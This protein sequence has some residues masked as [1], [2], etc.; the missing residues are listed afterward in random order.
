ME[1]DYNLRH[2]GLQIVTGWWIS[3][4]DKSSLESAI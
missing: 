3:K 1:R 2:K 4:C